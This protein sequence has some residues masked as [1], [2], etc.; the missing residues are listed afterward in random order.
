MPEAANAMP[1]VETLKNFERIRDHGEHSR[2]P[3]FG[4]KY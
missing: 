1:H 4:G 3:V 2:F